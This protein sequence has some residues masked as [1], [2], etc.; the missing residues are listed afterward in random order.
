MGVWGVVLLLSFLAVGC[1]LANVAVSK[2]TAFARSLPD[3]AWK[4]TGVRQLHAG[5]DEAKGVAAARMAAQREDRRRK[6]E[7][8]LQ[9]HAPQVHP[10]QHPRPAMTG[11][12]P[13][14]P[15]RRI[16]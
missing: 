13:F 12:V 14:D 7:A 5:Y 9:P 15:K 1:L 8:R 4:P 10:G 2:L 6:L 16:G 3:P 11:F